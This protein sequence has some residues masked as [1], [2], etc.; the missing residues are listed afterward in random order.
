MLKKVFVL[1]IACCFFAVAIFSS[2]PKVN[3]QPPSMQKIYYSAAYGGLLGGL[4]GAA[5]MVLGPNPNNHWDYIVKGG[6]VGV[7][8][9]TIYGIIISAQPPYYG[10]VDY[11]SNTGLNLHTPQIAMLAIRDNEFG[12]E[13]RCSA[14]PIHIRYIPY[15]NVFAYHF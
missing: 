4:L 2:V 14:T 5:I 1:L 12:V 13:T 8:C 7:I 9:G 15:V 11:S 6:A 10:L 3:A